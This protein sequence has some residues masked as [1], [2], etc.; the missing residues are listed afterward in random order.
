MVYTLLLS[1][2]VD[3]LRKKYEVAGNVNPF[4]KDDD[5][6]HVFMSAWS[7][8]GCLPSPNVAMPGVN[9]AVNANLMTRVYLG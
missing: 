8:W 1:L 6:A 3:V 4:R 5:R 2:S 9:S 7:R